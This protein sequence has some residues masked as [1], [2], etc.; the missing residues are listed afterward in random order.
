MKKYAVIVACAIMAMA[1]YASAG[2][3]QA[4]GPDLGDTNLLQLACDHAALSAASSGLGVRSCRRAS[5]EQVDGDRA[6][7]FV[8]I[9]THEAGAFQ[10][11]FNFQRSL[12]SVQ[13]FSVYK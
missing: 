4:P 12:W 3:A 2:Q 7:V 5:P 6:L 10:L 1:L 11:T 9:V 8:R 13:N